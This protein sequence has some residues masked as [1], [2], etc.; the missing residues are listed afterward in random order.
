MESV[1]IDSSGGALAAVLHFPERIPAPVIVCCHGLLSRKDS[2]KYLLIAER[3][4]EC[5]FAVVRFDFSGSGQSAARMERSL[6]GSRM[7]D[8]D[9]VLDYVRRAAWCSGQIGLLGSSLGGYLCLLEADSGRAGVEAVVCWA[10][11]FDLDGIRRRL[12]EERTFEGIFPAGL[13]LGSPPNLRE[14]KAVRGVLLVHGQQDEL[15]D[16]RQAL[17]IYRRAG[18]PRHL[19]IMKEGDHRFLDPHCR[20]LAVRWSLHWFIQR[21]FPATRNP[22]YPP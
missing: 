6:L 2:P 1:L 21:G 22:M 18:D 8:L 12:E 11:P 17:E 14:L 9:A 3:F 4:T 5:G 13:L 19:L 7:R 10:T 20:E 15:V 16:W